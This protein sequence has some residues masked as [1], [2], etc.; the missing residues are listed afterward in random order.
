[1]EHYVKN[2]NSHQLTLL[3]KNHINEWKH[4]GHIISNSHNEELLIEK[5]NELLNPQKMFKTKTIINMAIVV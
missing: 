4:L 3:L 5:I 2:S 1:M